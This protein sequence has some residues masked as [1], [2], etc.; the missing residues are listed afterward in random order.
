M[1]T[2]Q[3]LDSTWAEKDF[4]NILSIQGNFSC[5]NG[6]TTIMRARGRWINWVIV[7]ALTLASIPG[8]AI[9]VFC[10]PR[11]G[12]MPCCASHGTTAPKA[13][14]CKNHLNSCCELKSTTS[15]EGSNETAQH[16]HGPQEVTEK[17]DGHCKCE[18]KSHP[19]VDPPNSAGFVTSDS[20]IVHVDALLQP[21]F[22]F[23]AFDLKAFQPG[24][25]GIDSGPPSDATA[26]P[27]LGRAPPVLV[28]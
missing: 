23:Q 16:H 19:P 12:Q 22:Q 26:S 6:V 4:L 21:S 28:A 15:C 9:A 14:I 8:S 10:G 11:S 7:L 1:S 25:F 3:F 24:I 13:K 17:S 20:K 5:N 27:S 2:G 18:L